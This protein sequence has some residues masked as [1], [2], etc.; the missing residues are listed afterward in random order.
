MNQKHLWTV[1]AVL[2]TILGTPLVGCSEMGRCETTKKTAPTSSAQPSGDVVKL[3]EYKTPKASSALNAATIAKIHAHEMAGRPAATLYIRDIPVLT[4]MGQ[5]PVASKETKVGEINSVGTASKT[6]YS[7]SSKICCSA[8]IFGVP[9]DTNNS[10]LQVNQASLTEDD[11]VQR[12]SVVA[13][14]INQLVLDKA[15]ANKITVTWQANQNQNKNL[16]SQQLPSGRFLIKFRNQELVEINEN[17]RLANTT[18]DLALD[19]LQATNRLRRLIGNA[20]P[21]NQIANLPTIRIPAPVAKLPRQIAG[22]VLASF[23]GIASFYGYDGSGTRTATGERFN[24]EAMTAAHRSLPFGTRVRVTNTRN[25]RSVIV[26][27][28]DRGPYV[29]GRIIDLSFAAA[30]VL[31]MMSSGIAPVKIEVLGR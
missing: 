31:G 7:G 25:G 1:V 29:R 11:P 10:T 26:R 30:R 6:F 28:N 3:G 23:Q 27:I 18:K 16:S 2:S 19:A 20:S 5:K 22:T 17:T 15:D 12:A 9:F 8:Q 21:L 13:A 24:P 14:K 4:F